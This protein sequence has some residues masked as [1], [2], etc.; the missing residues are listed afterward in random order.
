MPAH[1][2]TVARAMPIKGPVLPWSDWEVAGWG[3]RQVVSGRECFISRQNDTLNH[4]ISGL[5][6]N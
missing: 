4:M 3:V 2:N 1:S 5:K 6:I